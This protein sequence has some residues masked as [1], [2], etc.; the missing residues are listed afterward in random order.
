MESADVKFDEYTEVHK[1]KPMKEPKEYESFVYFYEGMPTNEDDIN[2][3][4]NQQQVLVIV[5]SHTMNFE[6]HLG[7]E[8]HSSAELQIEVEAY[9]NFEISVHERDAYSDLEVERPNEENRE[10]KKIV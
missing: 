5:K 4:A 3:V 1:A 6:F 2:Q 9:S 10:K 8:I 7:T